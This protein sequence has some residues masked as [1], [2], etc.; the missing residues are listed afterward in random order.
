V[1][2]CSHI[3]VVSIAYRHGQVAFSV[4]IL[5]VNSCLS[6]RNVGAV[7]SSSKNTDVR[8]IVFRVD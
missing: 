1:L 3:H 6:I 8:V 4:V 2:S 7:V 5:S